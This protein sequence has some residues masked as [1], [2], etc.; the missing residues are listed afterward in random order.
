MLAV[1][2]LNALIGFVQEYRAGRAIQALAQLV[3]EPAR[4]RRDG[5]W[6]QADTARPEV[7]P[8]PGGAAP[9]DRAYGGGRARA[10]HSSAAFVPSGPAMGMN[11]GDRIAVGRRAGDGMSPPSRFRTLLAARVPGPR[12]PLYALGRRLREIVLYVSTVCTGVSM[13]TYCDG[14][15]SG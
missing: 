1:V 6:A 4:V 11:C 8:R 12:K 2:V 15:P 13:F 10:G 5:R 3:S 14:S 9:H 7:R